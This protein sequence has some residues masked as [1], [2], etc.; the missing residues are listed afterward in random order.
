MQL[1]LSG[2]KTYQGLPEAHHDPQ[3]NLQLGNVYD[4]PSG[5]HLVILR[6]HGA[7]LQVNDKF[8]EFPSSQKEHNMTL[9]FSSWTEDAAGLF[10]NIST[11][12]RITHLW[13][14]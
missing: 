5:D 10:G 14:K 9:G 8:K 13:R 1:Q 12:L 2:R 6:L 4:L 11:R 7:K 3:Y